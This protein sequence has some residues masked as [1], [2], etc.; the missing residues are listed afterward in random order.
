MGTFDDLEIFAHVFETGG[1]ARADAAF[2]LSRSRTS[3]SVRAL[4]ARLGALRFRRRTSHVFASVR[5]RFGHRCAMGECSPMP[6]RIFERCD[7]GFTRPA[8]G[9]ALLAVNAGRLLA[10]S[11]ATLFR[12]ASAKTA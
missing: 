3:E 2:G 12:S 5:S 9:T 10:P 4:E 8:T 1:F 6:R 11:A 7:R